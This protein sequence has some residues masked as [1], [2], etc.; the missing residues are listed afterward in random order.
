[1]TS[2][3]PSVRA[4][5]L[6][7]DVAE[8]ERVEPLRAMLIKRLERHGRFGGNSPIKWPAT[9]RRHKTSFLG[10]E[11]ACSGRWSN[12]CDTKRYFKRGGIVALLGPT[13]VGKT[14]TV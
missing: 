7:A 2:I 8:V 14:A 6:W 5:S 12:L 13:G 9:F 1:M 4:S 10:M 11:T 3:R